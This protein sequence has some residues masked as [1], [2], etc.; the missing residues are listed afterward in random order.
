MGRPFVRNVWKF[1][2]RRFLP[3]IRFCSTV[4]Q[5]IAELYF[6]QYGVRME[7]IRNLPWYRP[8][9]KVAKEGTYPTIIYQGS[10]NVGRG[11]ENVIKALQFL[12]EVHFIIAEKVTSAGQLN[13]LFMMKVLTGRYIL[14]EDF[15]LTNCTGKPFWLKWEYRL[16]KNGRK[17]LLCPAE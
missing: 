4:N 10:I 6:Q 8:T 17:L 15:C 16:R 13:N 2:E 9:M 14:P 11:I 3:R 5:Y 12:P 7:V 1:L